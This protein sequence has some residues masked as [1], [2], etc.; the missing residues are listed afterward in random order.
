[1]NEAILKIITHTV[2]DNIKL[3]E[4]INYIRNPLAT[5]PMITYCAYISALY[6]YEEMMLTKLCY[7]SPTNDTL[8][9]NHFFEF[10]ISLSENNSE[11]Y[12][13]FLQCAQEI[14][15]FLANFGGHFQ[16]I[17]CVHTN[18]DNLHIHII[19][20]NIDFMCGARLQI[21]YKAFYE[22]R[23]GTSDILIAHGFSGIS[24]QR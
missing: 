14:V 23:G 18:T 7:Q 10:V 6:P 17:G 1:M 20:N 2:N 3:L 15:A 13:E 9:G 11:K 4:R 5:N 16:T 21:P 22:I 12:R 19:I 24:S 8:S